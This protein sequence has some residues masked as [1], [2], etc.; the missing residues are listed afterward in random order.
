MGDDM[1]LTRA[2]AA[3]AIAVLGTL[4]VAGPAHADRV[5]TD[6][7][8]VTPVNTNPLDFGTVCRGTTTS[9]DVL[10]AIRR[11][12][13]ASK[14]VFADGSTVKVDLVPGPGDSDVPTA[15][16]SATAPGNIV[17][18]AGWSTATGDAAT[19]TPKTSTVTFTATVL[20]AYAGEVPYF[21][22]GVNASGAAVE[23]VGSL[24]VTANVVQCFPATKDQCKNGGW[25]SY[26][27][28]KNQGDCV[29]YVATGGRNAPA[30]V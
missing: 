27:I 25:A 12:G 22:H 30:R 9:K 6:G 3:T 20:G 24:R 11:A 23:R 26:G 1:K 8:N 13:T 21:A 29:S 7:D 14:E 18:P 2:A 15:G 17:L 10:I 16:L 19:S 28:F 5:I 4:G